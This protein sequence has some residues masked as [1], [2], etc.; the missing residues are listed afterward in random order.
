MG[1][2]RAKRVDAGCELHGLRIIGT[3]L[4]DVK[5]DKCMLDRVSFQGV[6][7]SGFT[8]Q[9]SEI[10]RSNMSGEVEHINFVDLRIEDLDL[11]CLRVVDAGFVGITAR[12]LRLPDFPD[13]FVVTEPVKPGETPSTS[14]Y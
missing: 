9:D 5:L 10:R 4:T 1:G 7:G 13:S 2:R 3:S 6:S 8:V 14:D 12:N 11:S